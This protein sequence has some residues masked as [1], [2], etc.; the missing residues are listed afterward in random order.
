[1]KKEQMKD[2]KNFILR[3]AFIIVFWLLIW[4]VLARIISNQILLEGPVGVLKRLWT[5]LQTVVYYKT[6]GAS[7]LRIM[8]GV[9]VG[10]LIAVVLSILSYKQKFVEEFLLPLIQF[11]KAAP[12]TCFV[13]LL[14]FLH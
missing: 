2:R 3:K 10:G 1:M 8:A 5:D 11:F 4:E 12:I 7:V 14:L 13:V 6:V 9:F